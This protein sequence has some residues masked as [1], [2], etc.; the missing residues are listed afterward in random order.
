MKSSQK[1][2]FKIDIEAS[3][4][5]KTRRKSR[6]KAERF[7]Q[8]QPV[9]VAPSLS[10]RDLVDDFIYR[11]QYK[12]FPVVDDGKLLGCITMRQVKEIPKEDWYNIRI[13]EPN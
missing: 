2:L 7:M 6:S 3:H 11:F 1:N 13:E 8:I 10:L 9:T 12:L 4:E 5:T